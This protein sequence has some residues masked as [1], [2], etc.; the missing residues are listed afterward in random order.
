MSFGQG[1]G[2]IQVS[3]RTGENV[4]GREITVGLFPL[5]LM[6]KFF[7]KVH[8]VALRSGR[9]VV[10]KFNTSGVQGT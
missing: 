3:D 6:K 9:R 4:F 7:Q 2:A 8:R 1:T 10:V 5:M